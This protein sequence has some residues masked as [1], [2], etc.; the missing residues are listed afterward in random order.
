MKWGKLSHLKITEDFSTREISATFIFPGGLSEYSLRI[1]L[2][3]DGLSSI[4][5]PAM[6]KKYVAQDLYALLLD[7]LQIVK[8]YSVTNFYDVTYLDEYGL[9]EVRVYLPEFDKYFEEHDK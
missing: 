6:V 7:V 2:F 8:G 3:D 1:T 5:W 9:Q 4:K